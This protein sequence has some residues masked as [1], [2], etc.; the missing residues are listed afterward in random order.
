LSGDFSITPDTIGVQE[1]IRVVFNRPIDQATALDPANFVVTDLCDTLRVPGS[2]RLAGDTLI[3]S[4]SQSLPFLT[5]LSV[6]VQNVLDTQGNALP[7]PITF[8]RIIQAPAV[9]DVSWTF[10]N[11]PTN[12]VVTGIN[13]ANETVGYA[14]TSGGSVYRTTNGGILF[15][16][17]FKDPNITQTF[18]VQTFSGDTVVFLGAVLTGGS[19]QWAVF[20]SVDS[21][22]TFA[23]SNTVNRQLYGSQLRAIGGEIVGVVG[24]QGSTPGLY[25]YNA[26]TN[27]LT[28]AAGAPTSSTV[29]FTD[30]AL[31]P[32]TTKA[33]ATFFNLSTNLG[34]A[35]TSLD[36]GANY[37]A[38]TLPSALPRL[39]GAGFVD[40]NTALV[41]G[42]SSTVLRVDVASG[43]V[44]A[45]GAASG[46]PQTEIAGAATTVFTF[47]RVRFTPGG[48]VGWITGSLRRRQPGTPD[49]VQGVILQSRDGGQ[50][51]TRQA[52]E[53]AA[54]NGLEF[55][56]IGALQALSP[57]FAAVSGG[58][59]LIAARTDDS[60]PAA[61]ACSFSQQ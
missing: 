36:G 32:D 12:D 42:D 45:L 3:F 5:L 10:L 29:L 50:T 61:A 55:P 17:R 15:G 23:R 24:G 27:T 53:G 47:S 16:A 19:P 34:S 40:D 4:P 41:M 25:R 2:I 26:A 58:S 9:S 52:I 18:N 56:A 54:E 28:A 44:T 33:I 14:L 1:A 6:R 21:A 30:A 39:R 38:L 49:V 46:I 8:Q 13:F 20:R 37:S 48:Q 57:D 11:S 7:Q 22:L 60:R 31:S 59:G 35:Y 51:W 43:Q